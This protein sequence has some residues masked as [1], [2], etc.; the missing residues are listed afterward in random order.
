MSKNIEN[1]KCTG[2]ENFDTVKNN[3]EAAAAKQKLDANESNGLNQIPGGVDK[4]L[5][6]PAVLALFP[7]GRSTWYEGVRKGIYPQPVR[8]STGM[9]AWSQEAIHAL[10]RRLAIASTKS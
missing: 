1:E 10:V 4:L 3:N 8:I 6:L 9:V 5:R 7:V 2:V